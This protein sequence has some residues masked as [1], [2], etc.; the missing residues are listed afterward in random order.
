MF[1]IHEIHKVF[2]IIFSNNAKIAIIIKFITI[3]TNCRE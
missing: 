2:N 3:S 1:G